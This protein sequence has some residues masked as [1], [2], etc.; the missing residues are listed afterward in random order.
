MADWT[1][2]PEGVVTLFAAKIDGPRSD[3]IRAFRGVCKPWREDI[4]M[5]VTKA[6]MLEGAEAGVQQ[7]LKT[8]PKLLSM[9]V[10]G[11]AWATLLTDI[12]A[13]KQLVPEL[14]SFVFDLCD[15][16]S[17]DTPIS[18]CLVET[19]TILE[20]RYCHIKRCTI[21]NIEYLR[22]LTSLTLYMT[23]LE[24]EETQASICASVFSLMP[25][26]RFIEL[27]TCEM[28]MDNIRSI[29]LPNLTWLGVNNSTIWHPEFLSGL[30]HLE[31]LDLRSTN[32][33]EYA[34]DLPADLP[35]SITSLDL[36]TEQYCEKHILT[37]GFFRL[38]SRL[39]LLSSLKLGMD[40]QVTNGVLR[41]F[42]NVESLTQLSLYDCPRVTDHGL[43]NLA[44]S[45]LKLLEIQ[46]C[47][48]ITQEGVDALRAAAPTIDI[49]FNF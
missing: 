17:C 36:H 19:T 37:E 40:D 28:R 24:S 7:V 8:T 32:V 42:G 46:Y 31:H 21:V 1:N 5:A 38:A 11:T 35:S 25:S 45:R 23:G 39:K 30:T 41:A 9:T 16:Y 10:A 26:L 12:R 2:L 27:G 34:G 13:V 14:T 15:L 4:S 29:D 20:L 33:A 6:T 47:W 43:M 49:V 44:R 22:S 48:R 18:Q 3:V